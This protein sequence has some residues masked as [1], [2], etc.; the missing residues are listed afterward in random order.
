MHRCCRYEK[1][2]VNFFKSLENCYWFVLWVFG[3]IRLWLDLMFINTMF[4]LRTKSHFK[5][6]FINLYFCF[7]FSISNVFF[8]CCFLFLSSNFTQFFNFCFFFR[9]FH[10]IGVYLFI[11][12]RSLMNKNYAT[13]PNQTNKKTRSAQNLHTILLNVF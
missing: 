4:S 6:L 1:W 3:R 13:Q 2:A 7:H 12:I 11:G 9:S 5:W 8:C 10:F